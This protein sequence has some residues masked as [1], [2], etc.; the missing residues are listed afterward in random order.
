VVHPFNV[1]PDQFL[2]DNRLN[3]TA[4]AGA[5]PSTTHVCHGYGI[6]IHPTTT[7]RIAAST[8]WLDRLASQA[9]T[10]GSSTP[11]PASRP[12]SPLPRRTS[13]SLGPYASQR[14]GHS[15]RGSSL[16]L[17]S[18]DSNTSLLSQ[19]RKT[20]ASGLRQS[21]T[22]FNGPDPVDVL[23]KLLDVQPEEQT[24]SQSFVKEADIDLEPDFGGL[25]LK[26]L[27]SAEADQ[28]DGSSKTPSR[29]NGVQDCRSRPSTRL[30]EIGH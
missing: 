21:S 19:Q 26:E 1:W 28:E 20:N 11:Q 9:H 3:T 12:Y 17:V 2:A 4:R 14:T 23:E 24:R 27:G 16:S 5:Y 13:S 22:A 30:A 8:M 25:S 18:N 6:P 29:Q 15:P 7:V 10:S